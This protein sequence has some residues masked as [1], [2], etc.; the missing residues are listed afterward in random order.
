MMLAASSGQRLQSAQCLPQQVNQCL[1]Q[2]QA[3]IELWF[4]LLHFVESPLYVSTT[5][6]PLSGSTSE[7]PTETETT[8]SVTDTTDSVTDTTDS[9]TDTTDAVTDTTDAVTDTTDSV[10]DTTDSVTDT[11]DPATDPATVVTER[12][13]ATT[14]SSAST[15]HSTTNSAEI[16][17]TT[18][19]VTFTTATPTQPRLTT[20][21]APPPVLD[22]M[23]NGDSFEVILGSELT[24]ECHVRGGGEGTLVSWYFNKEPL[25]DVQVESRDNGSD[26]VLLVSNLRFESVKLSHAG[27][28]QCVANSTL[29]SQTVM[30]PVTLSVSSKSVTVCF[31]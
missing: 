11:T 14:M 17:P 31:C 16:S 25:L 23:T 15:E 3:D 1:L 6:E 26:G 27:D 10:T 22:I 19:F 20:P 28:Y 9:V 21:P 8:V 7:P 13:K 30:A 2:K 24:I 4:S 18:N 29:H 5:K 12:E